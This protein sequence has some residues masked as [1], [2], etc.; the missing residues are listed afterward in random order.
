MKQLSINNRVVG[1]ATFKS[2]CFEQHARSSSTPLCQHYALEFY[3]RNILPA[4]F[5]A[6]CFEGFGLG[7]AL[8]LR[9]CYGFSP[10]NPELFC[11]SSQGEVY[12]P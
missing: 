7:Q 6:D 5:F 8:S 9:A 2:K 3:P 12:E 10:Q 4:R 1:F 11:L